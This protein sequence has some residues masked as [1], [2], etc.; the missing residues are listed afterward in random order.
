M[1]RFDTTSLLLLSL[2]VVAA[3]ALGGCGAGTAVG[4]G[5]AAGSMAMEE[6]GFETAVDDTVIEAKIGK[7]LFDTD[8]ETFDAVEIEVIEGR[9]LLTGEVPERSDRIEAVRLAWQ[10]EGVREV[11]NEVRIGT[12][13]SLVASARDV[14]IAATLRSKLTLDQEIKAINYKIEVLNGTVFL[15]G[16]A[17]DREEAE[18]AVNH[19]RGTDYVRKV[20]DHTRLKDDPRRP[21]DDAE[22]E[23][24]ETKDDTES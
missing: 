2:P 8:L 4:A 24:E 7:R 22:K 14:W 15:F 10:V 1:H 18:R 17:Q 16:I 11:V 23:D 13:E 12:T 21:K 20:I 5:A 9:V 6:R 3:L 19:A